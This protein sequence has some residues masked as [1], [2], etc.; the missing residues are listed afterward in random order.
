VSDGLLGSTWYPADN[1]L[2]KNG[3]RSRSPSI[4]LAS[5]SWGQTARRMARNSSRETVIPELAAMHPRLA[6]EP[7]QIEHLETWV[8]ANH[9]WSVGAYSFYYPGDQT[10]L[11]DALV[12]PEGRIVLAGEHASMHHSWIQGAIESGLRAAATSLK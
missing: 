2:E 11:H 10:E 9:P 7:D 5:Y 1:A 3:E 8:W 6:T 12:E 4:F